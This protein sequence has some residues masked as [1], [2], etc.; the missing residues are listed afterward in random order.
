MENLPDC[1]MTAEQ[2]AGSFSTVPNYDNDDEAWS[3]DDIGEL[4]VEV[5]RCDVIS[6]TGVLRQDVM[7]ALSQD[8]HYIDLNHAKKYADYDVEAF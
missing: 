7:S 5:R 4:Q 1:G 3:V 6:V 2:R 8:V